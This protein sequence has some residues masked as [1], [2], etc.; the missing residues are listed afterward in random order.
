MES[1]FWDPQPGAAAHLRELNN[2]LLPRV[3]VV[4]PR[5][6]TEVVLGEEG[7]CGNDSATTDPSCRFA[8]FR[9]ILEYK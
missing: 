5:G 4:D 2:F 7:D 9:N 8:F 6:L 3:G 1:L